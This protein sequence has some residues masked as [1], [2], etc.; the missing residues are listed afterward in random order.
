MHI[1]I[2]SLQR[3]VMIHAHIFL[4]VNVLYHLLLSTFAPAFPVGSRSCCLYFASFAFSKPRWYSV[5][6][7]K[8]KYSKELHIW[9]Y[10]YNG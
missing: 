5:A 2:S 6:E 4:T 7:K 1:C 3:Q 10:I 8:N 9:H